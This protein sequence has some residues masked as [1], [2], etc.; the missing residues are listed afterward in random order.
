MR[1]LKTSQREGEES[2]SLNVGLTSSGVMTRKRYNPV[3]AVF[4]DSAVHLTAA[5]YTTATKTLRSELVHEGAIIH[6][7]YRVKCDCCFT[8]SPILIRPSPSRMSLAISN[9]CHAHNLEV[10]KLLISARQSLY[11]IIEVMIDNKACHRHDH[12]NRSLATH[13]LKYPR[14][15]HS[16]NEL[17]FK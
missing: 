12:T 2:I 17:S 15:R 11:F 6:Y 7:C 10:N 4:A 3:F 1:C 16:S 9:I 13:I 5:D 8:K 14:S